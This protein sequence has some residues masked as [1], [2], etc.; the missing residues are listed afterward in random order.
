MS[1]ITLFCRETPGLKLGPD[2]QIVF[3]DGYA[4]VDTEQYPEWTD[5]AYHSGT[6]HIRVVDEGEST[7]ATE[8]SV[9]CPVCN[10]PFKTERA[11]NGHLLSHRPKTAAP[12][13]PSVPKPTPAPKAAIPTRPRAKRRARAKP[14]AAATPATS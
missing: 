5:W 8:E 1:K 13:T 14:K 9:L 11:L 7:S 12:A 2:N 10:R 6:P 3:V 4:D